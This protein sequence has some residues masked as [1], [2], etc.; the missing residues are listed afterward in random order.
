MGSIPVFFKSSIVAFAFCFPGNG[1]SFTENLNLL[2]DDFV[3]FCP[4]RF[5]L[6]NKKIKKYEKDCPFHLTTPF[7]CFYNNRKV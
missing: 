5:G 7:T 2:L 1:I 6:K 3:L 4:N